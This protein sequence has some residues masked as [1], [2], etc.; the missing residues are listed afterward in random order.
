[1]KKL[2]LSLFTLI[3]GLTS[4]LAD[5]AAVKETIIRDI[6]LPIEGK[7]AETLK[8]YTPDIVSIDM[9]QNRK[10]YY[11]DILLMSK[12]MDGK[13]PEEFMLMVFKARSMKDPDPNQEKAIREYAKTEK[14]LLTYPR[15][16][17]MM[18][19][20]VKQAC[21]I[22]LKTM[23]FIKVEIKGDLATVV[24]EYESLEVAKKE[25]NVT[26]KK[27]STHKLRKVNG[28]WMFYERSSRKIPGKTENKNTVLP[29]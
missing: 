9:D 23:K 10:L 14:F 7:F 13:H 12:G 27:T 17:D 28:V 5:E 1:M 22:E 6:K 11:K 2:L 16:C 25:L 29:M 4:L 26:V 19:S 3:L 18:T 15:V 21:E 20:Y 8:Y 24:T